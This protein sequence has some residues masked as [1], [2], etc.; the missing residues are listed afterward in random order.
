[1]S[2]LLEHLGLCPFCNEPVTFFIDPSQ[3][4]QTYIEDCT[5]CCRPIEVTAHCEPDSGEILAV[6]IRRS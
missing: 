3:E 1:M 4:E 5:V 6:T 2:L